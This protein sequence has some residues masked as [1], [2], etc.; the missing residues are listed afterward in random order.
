VYVLGQGTNSKLKSSPQGWELSRAKVT[1]LTELL[2]WGKQTLALK[3]F[4]HFIA[5]TQHPHP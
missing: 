1:G 2:P 3:V 5:F 4:K